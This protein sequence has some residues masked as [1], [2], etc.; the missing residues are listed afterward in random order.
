MIADQIDGRA[1]SA[2]ALAAGLRDGELCEFGS[3]AAHLGESAEVEK[4]AQASLTHLVPA[5]A[6]EVAGDQATGDT[7]TLKARQKGPH[8]G[9]NAMAQIRAYA[10]VV[11]L[12]LGDDCGH[13]LADAFSGYSRLAEH[14]TDDIAIQHSGDGDAL[15][16]DRPTGGKTG[17]VLQC[18]AVVRAR[19]R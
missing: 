13:P 8:A 16:G 14:E 4:L 5:D 2:E 19:S 10:R 9:T 15:A 12:R 3:G 1:G 6:R 7:A 18:Q 17:C 11:A